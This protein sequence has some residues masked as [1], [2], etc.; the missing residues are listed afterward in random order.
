MNAIPAGTVD[1]ALRPVSLLK[2][3]AGMELLFPRPPSDCLV[4][5]WLQEGFSKDSFSAPWP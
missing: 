4:R 2:A 3:L 5:W 1:V